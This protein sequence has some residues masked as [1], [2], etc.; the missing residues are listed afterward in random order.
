MARL[1]ALAILSAVLMA[2]CALSGPLLPTAS[3]ADSNWLLLASPASADFPQ[4]ELEKPRSQWT[5]LKEF[6]SFEQCNASEQQE[7]NQL[8]RAVDCIASDD[9]QL[10]G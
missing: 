3:R 4:G 1:Y 7:R 8:G 5:R 6:P 10:K 2:G 9:P